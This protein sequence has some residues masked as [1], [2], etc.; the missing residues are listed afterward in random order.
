MTVID[1]KSFLDSGH[2]DLKNIK[3]MADEYWTDSLFA[4][5]EHQPLR[6]ECWAIKGYNFYETPDV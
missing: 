6:G 4:N 3:E 5:I 2:F 1:L